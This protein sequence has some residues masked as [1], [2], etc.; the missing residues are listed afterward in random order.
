M[1]QIYTKVR[2]Y[3]ATQLMGQSRLLGEEGVSM[4]YIRGDCATNALFCVAHD[5]A[6]ECDLLYTHADGQGALGF[7]KQRMAELR[8][9][10]L[11]IDF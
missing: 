6:L 4:T 5:V 8:Y 10:L 7:D 2:F 11:M 1:I 9:F 3:F